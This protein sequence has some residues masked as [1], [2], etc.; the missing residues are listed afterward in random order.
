MNFESIKKQECPVKFWYHHPA[1]S[2]V[3][4]AEFLQTPDGKLYCRV[5]AG[6]AC[7]PRGEV[8]PGDRIAASD[9][10]QISLLGYIPHARQQGTFVPVELAPGETTEAEAA[11]LV[12]LTTA[13][14]SE[15]FWLGRN[16]AQLG[17][18]RLLTP[19]GP[20]IVTFGYERRPLGFSVKLAD[21]HRDTN[22]NAA[23]DA[24]CVS[25]VS[26]SEGTED[27]DAIPADNSLRTISTSSP[28]RY[29][30][31]TFHQSGF[32]QLAGGV[33][34]SV[35]RVT[36]DPGRLWKYLGGAMMCVGI[37][38]ALCLRV[39]PARISRGLPAASAGP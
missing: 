34:L 5:G 10:R 13:D 28:L 2:A 24:W 27:P 16:D 23:S 38:L 19:G 20:R 17:V 36:S 31:F 33:D 4:G 18:R 14:R 1:T 39:C 15:Q 37:L 22:P 8:K 11:A 21:F 32:Q 7:Q 26:L 6:G 25:H 3:S 35:L 9:G 29:G 12:E 30:P